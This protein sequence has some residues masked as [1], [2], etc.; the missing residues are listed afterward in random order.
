M[1]D[2]L[3]RQGVLSAA[4]PI[5]SNARLSSSLFW[6][7]PASEVLALCINKQDIAADILGMNDSL[8]RQGVRSA[9]IRNE[10]NKRLIKLL[11]QF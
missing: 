5:E 3:A 10:S 9:A 2:S 1:D 4:I 6:Q 11:V 7:L 8:V